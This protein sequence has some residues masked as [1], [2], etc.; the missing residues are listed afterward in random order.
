M[1]SLGQHGAV[2][3][4]IAL[5]ALALRPEGT[6]VQTYIRELLGAL[7]AAGGIDLAAVVQADVVASLPAGVTARSRPVAAGW[8]RALHGLGNYGPADVVHGLDVD[9]PLRPGAPTVAT[10]HDLSVF[11]VPWSMSRARATA[12]RW[13]VGRVLRRAD[14]LL[15]VSSFTAER[16]EAVSGRQAEV[17]LEGPPTDLAPALPEA[18]EAARGRWSMGPRSVLHV[19]TVEPR[20]GLDLLASAC[21]A[22]GADLVLAG[23]VPE[24]TAVPSGAR[25]IGYVDRADLPALYGAAGLVAY[26]SRYEGFGLPP[27][28]AMSCGA[29]VLAAN[30]S[31]LPEVLGDGAE[32]VDLDEGRWA[33]ALADLLADDDRRAALAQSGTE[34]VGG[35]SGMSWERAARETLAVYRRLTPG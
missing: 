21:R 27:L 29:P 34:W 6:G 17:V 24:G 28:E 14:V 23:R 16:I 10:V 31:S 11:D 5:N 32:L 8:R 20:K 15:A 26:P 3:P 18:V 30:T 35:R 9:L 19:G 13:L 12:E 7:A 33:A 1:P 25:A 4:T 2:P 22:A